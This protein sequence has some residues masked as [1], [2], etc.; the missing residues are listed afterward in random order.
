MTGPQLSSGETTVLKAVASSL[1]ET[2][3]HVLYVA[4]SRVKKKLPNMSMLL[5][6]MF[7]R[8]LKSRYILKEADNSSSVGLTDEGW[9]WVAENVVAD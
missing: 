8:N 1:E 5:F 9:K 6:K 4:L 3:P 2:E 7:I